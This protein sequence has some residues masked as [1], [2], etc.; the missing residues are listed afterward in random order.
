MEMATAHN[1]ISHL[2]NYNAS[3]QGPVVRKVRALVVDDSNDYL[4]VICAVLEMHDSINVV[5]RASNG[6]EAIQAIACLQPDL[7]L[8]DVEM[9]FVDG[10]TAASLISKR[11]ENVTVVLMSAEDSLS[12]RTACFESG[13]R[14]F[15]PKMQ[16]REEFRRLLHKLFEVECDGAAPSPCQG[17][18][19]AQ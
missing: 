2:A 11:Y 6:A 16:F 12:R 7:V 9:P 1:L 19:V 13:A 14:A 4:E 15:I 8:M 17:R 3:L 18:E 5:G 10:L